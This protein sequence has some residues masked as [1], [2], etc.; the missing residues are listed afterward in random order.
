MLVEKLKEILPQMGNITNNITNNTNCNNKRISNNQINIFLNDKCA[1]A[2]S[3]QQFAKQ[4]SFAI[5]DLMTTKQ[6]TLVNVIQNNLDPLKITER[7]VHCSNVAKR[8]WHVNDET[9]GW[10]KDDGSALIKIAEHEICKKWAP[11]F[12]AAHPNWIDNDHQQDEDLNLLNTIME[13][14]APK[15]E[16]RVLSALGETAKID[17]DNMK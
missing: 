11:M 10:K 4:I 1:D 5:K 2:M 14:V 17:V 12:E 6:D 7:P 15:V 3:I 13:T 8:K 16:A 9:E